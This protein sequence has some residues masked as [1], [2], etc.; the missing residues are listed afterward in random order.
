MDGVDLTAE[1]VAAGKYELARPLYI[2]VKNA[3]AGVIPGI[4]EFIGEYTSERALGDDGYLVDK[5]LIPEPKALRDAARIEAV[6]LTPL[7]F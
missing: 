2:Y 6:N 5:G 4:R 3:H 1:T 7:Q